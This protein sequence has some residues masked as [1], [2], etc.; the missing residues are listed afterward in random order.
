M[1][2]GEEREMADGTLDE[3]LIF[4]LPIDGV[5]EEI[6]KKR[7]YEGDDVERKTRSRLIEEAD[8]EETEDEDEEVEH[9][10]VEHEEVEM[11]E[12][13]KFKKKYNYNINVQICRFCF[14]KHRLSSCHMYNLIKLDRK[15]E[16]LKI[17]EKTTK[18]KYNKFH[19]EKVIMDYLRNYIKYY[20]KVLMYS[21]LE[22]KNK[23]STCLEN[24]PE[25]YEELMKVGK[26]LLSEE[27]IEESIALSMIRNI[28]CTECVLCDSILHKTVECP[29]KKYVLKIFEVEY[30]EFKINF[31]KIFT[32][33]AN[34][35][36]FN[37]KLSYLRG[38]YSDLL[39]EKEE[40]DK[41]LPHISKIYEIVD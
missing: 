1:S 4:N 25:K 15:E 40:L 10:E 3:L 24:F 41:S 22:I 23:R 6:K 34:S 33:K 32:K 20:P 19:V 12:K 37:A 36:Y 5:K 39:C 18:K 13:E 21:E 27:K 38:K 16:I 2:K 9:E 29:L 26:G 28:E 17:R 31:K 11:D 8:H 30:E 35:T 7:K 14:M